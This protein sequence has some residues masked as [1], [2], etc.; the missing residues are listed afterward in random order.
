MR[1]TNELQVLSRIL[2]ASQRTLEKGLIYDKHQA[3]YANSVYN[4]E[5]L[6]LLHEWEV[7]LHNL[8]VA[9]STQGDVF[10]NNQIILDIFLKMTKEKV[11]IPTSLR[12][13]FSEKDNISIKYV[14]NKVRQ[15]EEHIEKTN[16]EKYILLA[17][18]MPYNKLITITLLAN[19]LVQ[20]ELESLSSEEKQL[21]IATGIETKRIICQIQ[22]KIEEY[23]PEIK[24]KAEQENPEINIS[25]LEEFL[26]FDPNQTNV[27]LNEANLNK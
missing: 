2:L 3:R 25:V 1:K 17:D 24:R 14:L 8:I 18:A 12:N 21:A 7:C 16:D 9:I 22:R 27:L 13:R 5:G 11:D 10:Q 4:A 19:S 15:F 26:K 20:R 23:L 6:I